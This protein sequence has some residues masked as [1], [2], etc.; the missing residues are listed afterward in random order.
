MI[1][2]FWPRDVRP[3]KSFETN[4]FLLWLSTWAVERVGIQPEYELPRFEEIAI[5]AT[6]NI[7]LCAKSKGWSATK[8]T[9]VKT[10]PTI[11]VDERVHAESKWIYY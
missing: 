8:E 3:N 10:P 11:L 9:T 1:L 6:E 7:A 4:D 2:S 5:S